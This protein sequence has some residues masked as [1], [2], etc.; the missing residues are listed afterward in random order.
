MARAGRDGPRGRS[1]R[2]YSPSRG[3]GSARASPARRLELLFQGVGIGLKTQL[4]VH[5]PVHEGLD[6][7]PLEKR[8]ERVGDGLLG[9]Q[10]QD[11]ADRVR[12]PVLVGIDEETDLG[13]RAG[14]GGSAG[15]RCAGFWIPCRFFSP[16]P[17][18]GVSKPRCSRRGTNGGE[19][20]AGLRTSPAP[21]P[22]ERPIR[23][24]RPWRTPGRVRPAAVAC[25]SLKSPLGSSHKPGNTSERKIPSADLG[26]DP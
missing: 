14:S 19:R 6:R 13:R 22:G 17:T 26:G 23:R 16:S 7:S 10:G 5:D 15:G 24:V 3:H 25:R 21:W 8:I 2:S 20:G 12:F 9:G 1:D 4:L 11:R 18:H